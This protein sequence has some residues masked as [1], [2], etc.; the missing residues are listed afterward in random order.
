MSI[1]ITPRPET[2]IVLDNISWATFEA[3]VA[4]DERVSPRFAYDQGTLEIMSPSAAHEWFHRLV[5]RVIE[6]YTLERLIPIRSGGSTT[7]KA[8]LKERGLEPDECYYVS[9]E[10]LVRGRE[11]IDLNRDPAPD[12]AIE[13][14]ISR[15]AVNK[16]AIYADLGV[17]EVWF[18]DGDAIRMEVMQPDGKFAPQLESSELPGLTVDIVEA[19]LARRS[20]S[21][22]TT[23]VRSIHDWARKL[24][25]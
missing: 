24:A 2:R 3:L 4:D 25:E 1:A 10:P 6:A 22:E 19:F 9:R 8:Q 16:L 7:M 23:W 12:L 18:Y 13:V 20:D 5:G 21:D 17:R 15:S 11:K 14:E